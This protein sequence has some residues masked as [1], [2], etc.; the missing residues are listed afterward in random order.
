MSDKEY[1]KRDVV[2][3]EEQTWCRISEKG[4]LEYLDWVFIEQ[5]ALQFDV[6]GENGARDQIMTMCKLISAAR[7]QTLQRVTLLVNSFAGGSNDAAG[8]LMY[9][10]V[11]AS[12]PPPAQ[13]AFFHVGDDTSQP[14]RLVD[15]IQKTNPE[16]EIWMLTDAETPV[17]E[18]TKRL[19]QEIDRDR[20]MPERL[21]CYAAAGFE[22]P[23]IYLDTDMVVRGRINTAAILGDKKYTFCNR[24][25]DRMVPFNGNQR[26]LD[27]SEHDGK[28]IGL[29]YPFIACFIAAR[30]SDD[31]W[32]IFDRC[33]ILSDTYQKWYGDQEALREFVHSL[34][35]EEFNLVDE[36]VFA[37]LPEYI[38]NSSPMIVHYKGARKNA[39]A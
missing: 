19:E 16:S 14:L 36:A 17:V 26:G 21:R 2:K 27:F 12:L 23:T 13:F 1:L 5:Q 34:K 6:A 18:G 25:F 38:G 31:L 20:L 15:S 9:D 28:P 29:V 10:P 24:S 8:V 32:P 7:K 39:T 35:V 4:E 3:Q 33:K 22:S 11:S 37:C 30:S